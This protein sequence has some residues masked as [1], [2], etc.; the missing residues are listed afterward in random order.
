M[1]K[2][3]LRES[4]GPFTQLATTS[5]LQLFRRPTSP[6]QRVMHWLS[7]D[8][9]QW[10]GAS[11]PLCRAELQFEL[12]TLGYITQKVTSH[13]HC[14]IYWGGPGCTVVSAGI[15]VLSLHAAR[16]AFGSNSR[17]LSG[18]VMDSLRMTTEMW[19]HVYLQSY[20]APLTEVLLLDICTL[21][22]RIVWMQRVR[23]IQKQVMS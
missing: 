21:C 5:R 2:S 20:T 7:V 16:S 18:S 1:S 10:Q 12:E 23:A 17:R 13:T 4:V 3:A 8:R 22:C 11:V 9:S 14:C 6:T 19:T 15:A